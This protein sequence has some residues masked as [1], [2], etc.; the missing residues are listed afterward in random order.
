MSLLVVSRAMN[1]RARQ[2][3]KR[4]SALALV[5]G[6]VLQLV[7]AHGIAIFSAPQLAEAGVLVKR[8]SIRNTNTPR[9]HTMR[10]KASTAAGRRTNPS[11]KLKGDTERSLV[12]IQK[13]RARYLKQL[14]R[15]QQ[16]KE[17]NDKRI[18]QKQEQ[19]LQTLQREQER[20]RVRLAKKRQGGTFGFPSSAE[21]AAAAKAGPR[22]PQSTVT[23]GKRREAGTGEVRTKASGVGNKPSLFDRERSK[24]TG[25]KKGILS[26]FWKA[27][28]G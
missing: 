16:Q 26:H 18:R 25:A 1:F 8:V 4:F 12:K 5:S 2:T 27:L 24:E 19:Q 21:S 11:F 9:A 7:L 14:Q 28:F 20:E 15:W 10:A 23:V 17:R 3:S 22:G 6:L 13:Q